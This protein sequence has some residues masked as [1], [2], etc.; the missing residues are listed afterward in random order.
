MGLDMYLM[1]RP[2]AT[3]NVCYWRKANAIRRWI[4]DHT[5]KDDD[6]NCEEV[7][8]TKETLEQLV[9]DCRE[10]LIDHSKADI[11]LPTDNNG[12]CFGSN[13][14]DE[15]YFDGLLITVEKVSDILAHTDFEAEEIIYT[16]WW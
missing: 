10:V 15:G 13:E 14:Y 11:L 5:G 2:R 6:F 3:E 9:S 8:L 16:D 4:L 1:R 7:E 12:L